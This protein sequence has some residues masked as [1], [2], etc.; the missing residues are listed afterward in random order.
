LVLKN[1]WLMNAV[2]ETMNT[3][4]IRKLKRPDGVGRWPA[5][6]L[7]EDSF[8]LWLYSPRGCRYR[9]RAGAI[10]T[11]CEVGQGNRASGLPVMHLIPKVGWWFAAWYRDGEASI[12][13]IDICTPPIL[14]DHEWHYTDLELD[15]HAFGDGRVEVHDESEFIAACEAGLISS[16]EAAEARTTAAEIAQKLRDK[17][18]PFGRAGWDKLDQALDLTLPPITRLSEPTT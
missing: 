15:P 1:G 8:G 18:E 17:R 2:Y 6:V 13:G 5:Y 3:T 4:V 16:I 9:G 10:V 11:E 7:G 14:V 12:I